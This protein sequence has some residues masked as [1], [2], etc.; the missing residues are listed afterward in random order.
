MLT[1]HLFLHIDPADCRGPEDVFSITADPPERPGASGIVNLL[2]G[3]FR[4]SIFCPAEDLA[5][6]AGELDQAAQTIRS[7]PETK[8]G[9]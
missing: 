9:E 6:L 2:F 5:R 1:S 7:F 8:K 3:T 4:V